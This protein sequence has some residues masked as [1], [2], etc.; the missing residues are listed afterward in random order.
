MR[1]GKGMGSER[2]GD[3]RLACVE[4]LAR[5]AGRSNVCLPRP[6]KGQTGVKKGEELNDVLAIR[7][8]QYRCE[9]GGKTK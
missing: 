2:G 7:G 4:R 6:V 9:R 8:T 5:N 3:V 1:K